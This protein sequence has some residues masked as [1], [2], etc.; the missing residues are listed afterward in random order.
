MRRKETEEKIEKQL[1]NHEERLSEIKREGWLGD[2][3]GDEVAFEEEYNCPEKSYTL[4]LF[5]LCICGSIC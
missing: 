2:S 4:F 5:V 1:K 3:N